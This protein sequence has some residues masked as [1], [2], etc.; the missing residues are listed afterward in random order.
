MPAYNEESRLPSTLTETLSY[1]RRR[2]DRQGS[3]FTFEVIIVDDGSQ[4][5]T[6]QVALDAAARLGDSTV[7]VL[8]LD[9]NRGKGYAVKQGVLAARG[10]VILML[11]ADGA[12]AVDDL[13]KL[14]R[15]LSLL[16]EGEERRGT[17]TSLGG[18]SSHRPRGT[19]HG[20]R[21]G[22]IVGSR[23]HLQGEASATRAWYRNI[24]M[25]GFHL[26]VVLVAGNQIADTQCGFKL[27]S[28]DAARA[29]FVNQKLQRWCF[30]V[31]LIHLA[32]RLQI[33][34]KEVAVRW[35]EIAGS[36]IRATSIF[37][38]AYEIL[39]LLVGYI[40]VGMWRP[41]RPAE[42]ERIIESESTPGTGD[43]KKTT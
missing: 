23:A 26:L 41:I 38:M 20:S 37:H 28:R 14:E 39:L 11:D 7:R 13:E 12:T 8:K 36:K 30:D 32:T 15:A 17:R 5:K 42:L 33:P 9:R 31:E 19:D 3:G 34:V 25:H 2:R 10:E 29:I 4:D 18:S 35:T 24:L 1:L 27:F 21:Y 16:F 22:V 43:A 40:V 6:S